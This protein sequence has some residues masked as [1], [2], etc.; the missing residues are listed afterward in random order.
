LIICPKIY[1]VADPGCSFRFH[2]LSRVKKIPDPGSASASK[3]FVFLKILKIKNLAGYLIICPKI[4]SVADPGCSFWFHPLSRVKK[5]PD[6]GSASA[7]NN[8]VF[9][10]QKMFAKLS[11]I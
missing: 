2:P 3:N 6:P 1:S 8:F 4:Y 11:E 7:S 9:L 10:T 5:I